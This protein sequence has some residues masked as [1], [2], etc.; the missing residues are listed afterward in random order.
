[1]LRIATYM[2]ICRKKKRRKRQEGKGISNRH[3]K[4]ILTSESCNTWDMY[5]GVKSLND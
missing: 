1:M 3:N 2:Y 4:N 5:V